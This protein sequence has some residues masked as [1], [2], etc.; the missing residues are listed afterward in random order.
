MTTT[1]YTWQQICEWSKVSTNTLLSLEMIQMMCDHRGH[2]VTLEQV[3]KAYGRWVWSRED[4]T[5]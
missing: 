3:M 1:T 2:P 5:A 4:E